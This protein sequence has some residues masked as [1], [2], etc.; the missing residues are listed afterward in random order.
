ME[1]ALEGVA[2]APAPPEPSD[3]R[4]RRVG[5]RVIGRDGAGVPGA[6]VTL[7]D[8]R[9]CE[10]AG[11][12]ADADGRGSAVAPR[13]GSYVL[14]S[15]APDHQPGAVAITVSGEPVTA[16]ILL[17]RSASLAGTVRGEDGP[18]VG[19]RL[20]LLQDGEIVDSARTGPGGGYRIADLAAGEYGLSVTAIE[21][22]PAT[23]VVTVPE[24]TD[25]RCDVELDPEGLTRP[26]D[27]L[28]IGHG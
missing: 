11:A 3:G 23:L 9:G 26:A 19:A 24:E 6:G 16:E 28:M 7:L 2:A 15:A 25:L 22:E 27:G 13:P 10:A 5:F 8:D 12:V 17:A 4:G 21:C 20:T 1:V 18:V 14:V